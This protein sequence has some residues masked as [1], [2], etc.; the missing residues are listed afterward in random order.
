MLRGAD[1]AL[2]LKGTSDAES[3][4]A[5][6]AVIDAR[7]FRRLRLVFLI[8][9]NSGEIGLIII[10]RWVWCIQILVVPNANAV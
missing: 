1:D 7:N 8:Q 4:S 6:E 3:I 2:A 5:V 10:P 9:L